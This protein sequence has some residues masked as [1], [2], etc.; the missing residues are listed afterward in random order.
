MNQI[1]RIL[2]LI[3]LLFISS[4][5]KKDQKIS[6]IEETDME[7]QM[8]D[9]YRQ[10]V[11]ALEMGDALLA[12]KKFN[13]SELLFP[14]SEWAAKSALMSAYSYYSQD[15]YGDAIFEL[16]R[17]FK[18]YPKNESIKYAYY[19]EAMC[20]YESIVDEKKDLGPLLKAKE[21]FEYI[22]N[23][24]PETDFALDAEYKLDLIQDILAAKEIYLGKHYMKREKWIAAINRFKNVII[25]YET[26]IY[27]EEALHRLVEIYYK[28]GLVE[29]SKRYANLLGYNYLSS[30]WYK[31]SYRVFNKDYEIKNKKTSKKEDKNF[32]FKKF[33][34]VFK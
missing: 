12:A 30:K 22:I 20:Y 18:R 23:E 3:F 24:Y 5:S 19:L 10:A 1:I 34:S 9:S 31:E 27:V 4:C 6:T 17:F 11:E 25:E 26:T 29:E 33:K 14:Q 32:I 16:E 7:L 13:E 15:Y 8:I 21:K 28:I 2:I